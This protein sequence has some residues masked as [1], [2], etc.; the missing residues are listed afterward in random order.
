MVTES[1]S[2]RP[3]PANG[4]AASRGDELLVQ[5]HIVDFAI[6]EE[7]EVSLGP[8]FNVLTGETGA[9]KSII[10]GAAS[11]LRGGRMSTD[12]VR[13][14]RKEA[15][16]EALFD[17]HG[18]PQVQRALERLG[19]PNAR[20]GRELLV[21]RLLPRSG[22]GRVYV[23]GSLCT[24]SVLAALTHHLMDISGQHEH[25][26][27][28]DRTTHRRLLDA[29]GLPADLVEGM[30][31][32]HASVTRAGA[33]LARTRMDERQRSERVDFL[34]FQLEELE[35]AAISAGEDEALETERLRLQ[36][37]AELIEAA[38]AAEREL[39]SDELSVSDRLA[40]QKKRL[41]ALLAADARLATFAGQLDEARVL[42]EDVAQGLRGY[43]AAIEVD[44]D[45][46]RA[47]EERL[48]RIQRLKRK[49]GPSV[50]EVLDRQARMRQEL[51]E[52]ESI[53]ER[54]MRLEEALGAA[55]SE[56][57][58]AAG[59]LTS[60]RQSAAMKLS[61]EV[62]RELAGLRMNG[63]RLEARVTPRSQREGDDPAL[64]FDGK[65]LG[66]SGWDRVEF[67]IATAPGAEVLPLA[68]TASGGE[69]SR[70]ML[71][72]RKVL[73]RHDPVSTSIY[74]EV[75]AGIGGAVADVV[76]RALAQVARHRQVLCVTHLP[77][78]AVHAAVHHY[79]SKLGSKKSK[80]P[81]VRRLEG[82]ER[83][84]ELAR[85]L[86]GQEVSEAARANA[87]QLLEAARGG[88]G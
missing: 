17:L 62:T 74:D 29:V 82:E 70:I 64:C 35:A 40:R 87:R 38:T 43:G 51:V 71:A 49:H 56:A 39:Y 1:A 58:R 80:A 67:L 9:G 53:E 79:V 45:R 65:R 24:L 7:V 21:R 10:V 48:V 34:R 88:V 2:Q 26:L 46:L 14:G 42:V 81:V 3:P 54:E 41:E 66:A 76:G 52:L 72:L 85:L 68:R 12:W 25:Q 77:Q 23:N 28:S 55:R 5:L 33:D 4:R 20:G 59:A 22:R 44:D 69:L 27:L 6:I 13:A 8:G 30:K 37:A 73:G 60:A 11:L 50:A 75:D 15:V 32:R 18:C 36:R 83:I 61:T 19:L 84:E 86:G 47:I 78:V 16:V 63:A 57:E 31:L